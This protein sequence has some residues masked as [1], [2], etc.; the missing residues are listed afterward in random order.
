MSAPEAIARSRIAELSERG[1]RLAEA[2]NHNAALARYEEAYGLLP[3]PRPR[4]PTA[5]WLLAA[6]GDAHFHRADFEGCRQNLQRALDEAGGWDNA[7]VRLRLGQAL[8]ELDAEDEAYTQL[9]EAFR[10]GGAD[11][12]LREDPK[13]MAWLRE[14]AGEE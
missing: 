8:L 11:L 4:H 6:I 2:G 1:D 7:F 5:L 3:E 9:F 14:R 10:L 13:Y 12:F